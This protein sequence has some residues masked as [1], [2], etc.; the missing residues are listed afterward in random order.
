M[1]G[2]ENNIGNKMTVTLDPPTNT[3][4]DSGSLK[5]TGKAAEPAWASFSRSLC[6][7]GLGLRRLEFASHYLDLCRMRTGNLNAAR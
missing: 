4:H 7:Q 6:R 3:D 2:D 1:I 5:A